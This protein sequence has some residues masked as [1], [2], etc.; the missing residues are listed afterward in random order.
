MPQTM[1]ET[2]GV[3]THAVVDDV[4][5]DLPAPLGIPT[6]LPQTPV[7]DE[8][9][10]TTTTA[11]EPLTGPSPALVDKAE[12]AGVNVSDPEK[13]A[14]LADPEKGSSSDGS[15]DV[16]VALVEAERGHDIKL[17]TMSWQQTAVL[18][19]AEYVCL[20]IAA[21]AWSYSILG[22]AGGLFVTFGMGAMTIYTSYVMWQYIMVHPEVR[23]GTSSSRR[24]KLTPQFATSVTFSAASLASPTR[25]LASCC[26]PTTSS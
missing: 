21:Q 20:A 9:P 18:L 5:N 22:M 12:Q 1:N 3:G 17:R 23:N 4:R 26:S 8:L 16:F 15:S 7:Y 24:A 25:L 6:T 2:E 19:F 14:N 13:R 10:G 11:G